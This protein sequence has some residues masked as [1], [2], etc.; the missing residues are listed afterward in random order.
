[1][2]AGN[3]AKEA[4]A[5]MYPN[6]D[7]WENHT[8]IISEEEA[9]K[10]W[11]AQ[12]ARQT[13]QTVNPQER[14]EPGTLTPEIA[15]QRQDIARAV[16][17]E[18]KAKAPELSVPTPQAASPAMAFTPDRSVQESAIQMQEEQEEMARQSQQAAAE[19]PQEERPADE[20]Y[21]NMMRNR[22]AWEPEAPQVEVQQEERPADEDYSNMMRNRDDWAPEMPKVEE[23]ET[24]LDEAEKALAIATAQGPTQSR[25]DW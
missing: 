24:E 12:R 21:S 9:K 4:L 15:Q 8:M 13:G 11:A 16:A 3:A 20:D 2:S 14:L 6:P 19:L 25:E 7:H 18:L 22:D 23:L 5:R 10:E 17:A 1:M